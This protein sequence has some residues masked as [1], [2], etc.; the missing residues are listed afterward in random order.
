MIAFTSDWWR[1]WR[2]F[3]KPITEHSK[4]TQK[5]TQLTFNN[6]LKTALIA[7]LVN[8]LSPNSDKHLNSPHNITT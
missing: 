4:A 1:K 3:F 6:Q 8:P 2:E 7:M 5:K